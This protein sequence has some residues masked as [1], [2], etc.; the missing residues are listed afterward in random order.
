MHL[1]VTNGGDRGDHHVKTIK[2][3][4]VLNV[5]ESRRA[6]RGEDQ[7]REN[8]ELKQTKPLQV[9]GELLIA[10]ILDQTANLTTETRRHREL[11]GLPEL[12]RLPGLSADNLWQSWH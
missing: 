9:Q 6:R 7:Q 4:P 1:L 10:S 12:P 3:A 2:P 5:V 11:P 8:D